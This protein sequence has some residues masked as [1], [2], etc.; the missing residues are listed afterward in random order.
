MPQGFEG[1]PS[2]GSFDYVIVGAGSAGC[3]WPTACRPTRTQRVAAAR[4]R[5]QG[6]L[7]LDPHSQSA[8]ST[9]MNNPRTD[10][11][12][13]TEPEAGLNGRALAYPRGRVLGGCSPSTA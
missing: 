13:K 8:T 5:R 7:H 12:F 10:W 3:V 6:Q 1:A 2:V 9:P 11:C 4:G